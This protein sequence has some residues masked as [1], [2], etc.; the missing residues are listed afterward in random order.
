MS[1]NNS[2]PAIGMQGDSF[3]EAVRPKA[4]NG[5]V[6]AFFDGLENQVNG[7]IQDDPSEVTPQGVG[8]NMAS[9]E[10]TRNAPTSGSNTEAQSN[11]GTDWKKRYT[12]SSREAVRLKEQMNQLKPFVPVLDAMKKDSG[13]VDHVREYLETGGKPSKT[14]KERLQLDDD[15]V[16]DPGDAYDNPDSDSAKLMQAHIDQ[17]VTQRVSGI[18]EREKINAAKMRQAANQKAQE[19]EFRKKHNMSDEQYQEFVAKAKTHVMTLEDINYI[20]NRDQVNA[21]TRNATKKDMLDQMKNVR[22]M[23]TSASGA[24][25]QSPPSNPDNDIFDGLVNMDGDVD[26]LFG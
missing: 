4:D 12:D 6:N 2:N 20:L 13:L 7:Q 1:D 22:S 3:E 10:A 18:L 15:F 19:E 9:P 25:S 14:M 5:S 17:A 23:P 24:N 26:N 8:P 11:S 16:F 21:N